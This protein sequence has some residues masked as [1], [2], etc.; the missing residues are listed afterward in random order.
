MLPGGRKGAAAV[1]GYSVAQEL[2]QLAPFFGGKVLFGHGPIMPIRGRYGEGARLGRDI[3][4][5]VSGLPTYG[6]LRVIV[7]NRDPRAVL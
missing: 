7:G 3:D 1:G 5:V 2:Q 6:S 4:I